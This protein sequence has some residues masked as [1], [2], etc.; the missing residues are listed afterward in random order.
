MRINI[1]CS[2]LL[3]TLLASSFFGAPR[4]GGFVGIK[5]MANCTFCGVRSD[6]QKSENDD[7]YSK[8]GSLNLS[9]FLKFK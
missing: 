5:Q 8:K 6:T 9:Y 4:G 3:S 1:F 2:I 7:F